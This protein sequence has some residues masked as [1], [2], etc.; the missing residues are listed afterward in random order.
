MVD[1]HA[2]YEGDLHTNITHGPSGK[3]LKTDAPLDNAGKGSEFSPTDLVAAA[4]SSC[5]LTIMG[6]IGKQRGIELKGM[7]AQISKE[8]SADMPRR[9]SQLDLTLTLPKSIKD[10]DRK[11][12]E[13]GAEMCPVKAS[14]HPEIKVNITFNYT[15]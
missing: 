1:M 5:T 7:K 9:I 11:A 4:L 12:L 14:L 15:A 8:M 13:R 2:V 10:A 6:L 3:N